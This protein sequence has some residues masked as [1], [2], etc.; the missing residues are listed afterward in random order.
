MARMIETQKADVAITPVANL[1]SA[2][3]S[4]YFPLEEYRKALAVCTVGP[5][6]AG[7][8]C[9]AILYEATSAA[10]AGSQTILDE[11]TFTQGT[12]ATVVTAA[13]SN[14]QVNDTITINGV[15]FTAKAAESKADR[16]FNQGGDDTA[17]GA[18]LAA[19]IND[20]TYGV[21]GVTASA[22]T[23]TVTLTSTVPGATTISVSQTGGTITL[24]DTQQVGVLE[25]D[26]EQLSDGFTHLA[27]SLYGGAGTNELGSAVMVRAIPR[28]APVTQAVAFSEYE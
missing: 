13:L 24:I 9:H 16:Q 6:A 19:C 2:K 7:E 12:N 3:T 15:T 27:V 11:Q 25:L 4:R 26:A 1:S 17:D 28:W 20:A 5:L 22:N 23:G 14:V 8:H 10:G 18:S 21:D